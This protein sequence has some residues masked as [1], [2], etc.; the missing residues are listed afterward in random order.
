DES[1]SVLG[2][3]RNFL[4]LAAGHVAHEDEHIHGVLRAHGSSTETLDHQHGDHRAAFA[5]LEKLASDVEKAWPKHKKAACRKLYLAFAAYLAEDLAHMH[6]E[7]TETAPELWRNFTD[8]E[9]LAIELN[10]VASM[11]PEENMAFLR[12]MIPAM[13]PAE[14]A[15][16]LGAMQQ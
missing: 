12:L 16:M 14:R 5:T 1:G 9:L 15:A 3:L 4:V 10:I 13:N 7:E 6:E 11:S 8:E 2:S